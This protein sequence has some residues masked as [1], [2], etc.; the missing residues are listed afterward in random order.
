VSILD[1]ATATLFAVLVLILGAV[2]LALTAGWLNPV[3]MFNLSVLPLEH[4]LTIGLTTIILF[5]LAVRLLLVS[6]RLLKTEERQA[7]I[8]NADLGA[9]SIA[10]PALQSLIV[11]AAR[12]V[13]G[14]WE[15]QPR[16]KVLTGGLIVRLDITVSPDRNIPELTRKLQ[17]KVHEYIA[18]TAG[19]EVPEVQVRVK[20]IHQE[21]LRRVE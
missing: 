7:L 19:L 16:F 3:A 2:V 8:S 14:V 6:L 13:G 9:V 5:L 15:V 1:R 4:R 17:D 20:G 11:R 10:M 12:Q 21:G 18:A